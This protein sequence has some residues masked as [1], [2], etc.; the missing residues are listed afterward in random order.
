MTYVQCF[1]GCC[2]EQLSA[3]KVNTVAMKKILYIKRCLIN[4][5]QNR[6][7]KHLKKSIYISCNRYL[8]NDTK[9]KGC[10]FNFLRQPRFYCKRNYYLA[11]TSFF[12]ST[13]SPFLNLIM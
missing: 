3:F 1:N 9:R 10:L 7:D 11:I 4:L 5:L 8:M 12:V 6:N 2:D 13:N